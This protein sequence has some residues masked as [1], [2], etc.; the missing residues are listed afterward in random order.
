MSLHGLVTDR[1]TIIKKDGTLLQ[2]NV[3]A[4]V[5]A[6][7]IFVSDVTLPIELGD[8]ILRQLPSKLSED[9]IVTSAH[10]YPSPPLAHWEIKY[11]RSGAPLAPMQTI[12]NN[13]SGDN[14]RVNI[15]STDNSVNQY[16]DRHDK[17]FTQLI[18]VVRTSIEKQE[19]QARLTALIEAM[20]AADTKDAQFSSYQH[21]VAGVANHMTVVAP[22]LP[23]L[24]NLL[25]GS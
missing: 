3:R 24:T 25:L 10:C 4:S 11:R 18:D 16:G 1:I 21:F 23:A 12:I 22:F 19:E 17:L 15:N 2:E 5:Q 20:K 6:R 13:I 9:Y 14:A 8:H 7:M